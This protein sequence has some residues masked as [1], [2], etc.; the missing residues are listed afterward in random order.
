MDIETPSNSN[1]RDALSFDQME[2]K[3]IAQLA[4]T[5]WEQRGKPVNS[6]LE[7]WLRAEQEVTARRN[8]K[9]AL[10]HRS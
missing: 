7:D 9:T 5:Y 10:T 8:W 3:A 6:A 4:Y 2:Q 1:A